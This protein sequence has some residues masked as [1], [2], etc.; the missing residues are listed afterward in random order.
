[1][2]KIRFLILFLI[3]PTYYINAQVNTPAQKSYLDS[4]IVR[5]KEIYGTYNFKEAITLSAKLIEKS[6]EYRI[7]YPK[8]YG[9]DLLANVYSKLDDS[10]KARIN[11]QKAIKIAKEINNDT[12]IGAGNLK[13]GS[14]LSYNTNTYK[15]GIRL[16]E[17]SISI[18][19]ESDNL[20]AIHIAY[21]NITRALLE[22]N[23]LDEAY[24][25][26]NKAHVIEDEIEVSKMSKLRT[27]FLLATY[28]FKKKYYNLAEKELLSISEDVDKSSINSLGT[29][30]Y[31]YL[32]EIYIEKKNYKK[33][34][35]CLEKEKMYSEKIYA[36]KKIEAIE[37]ASGQFEL[38]EYRRN[39]QVAIKDKEYAANDNKKSKQLTTILI[40]ATGILLLALLGFFLLFSSRK[41]FVKQL[42]KNN[43]ELTIAK[44]KAEKLSKVKSQ[45]FSTVSHEL[46]TPLYGVI[47]ISSILQEDIKLKSHQKELNSLKFSADYL[48]ALINDV[49]LLNK[50]DYQDLV[51]EKIPFELNGLVR[52]ITNSFEF[53]LEQNKNRLYV[54]I[55]DKIPNNLIGSTVRISQILMNIIGNATKFNEN[56][57]IWLDITSQGSINED[58]H[59]ILFVI[60]DD[61]IGI[62]K[63]K[64]DTIFEE[65]SQVENHNYSHKGTGLGLPIV[66]K[67]LKLHNSDIHLKSELGK[68]SEFSFTLDLLENKNVVE[69]SSVSNLSLDEI[70]LKYNEVHVLVVD[71]NKINQKV[72]QRMLERNDIK[73]SVANDGEEAVKMTRVNNYQLILMDINMPKMNGIEAT[74][75]IRTFNEDIPIIA[76][77]AV[78][79]EE[80]RAE[81]LASGM[82]GILSKPYDASQFLS[83][84]LKSISKRETVK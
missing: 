50:M 51:L 21:I 42:S 30:V 9:Y 53:S 24:D 67:L 64:Q 15:K 68:G 14:I 25:Y 23:S 6:D 63:E 19:H 48:L 37:V 77:T 58:L 16:L 84:I 73:S 26:L 12:L 81:I 20:E 79:I 61:G 10:T 74:K 62:P 47:G 72:T 71:D 60:K 66:R 57:N 27:N 5:S 2:K 44:N 69:T 38:S 35:S 33:A 41:K 3:F 4:L 59:R 54:S 28:Y 70:K 45:F 31:K 75:V 18:Y 80:M 32:K 43:E 29:I 78:E 22:N 46:R 36:F 39:L 11:A 49:L 83:T 52:S 56:G 1:M 55:D 17:E 7:S 34:F 40:I 8:Y 76:L 65:F 82:N 13:L